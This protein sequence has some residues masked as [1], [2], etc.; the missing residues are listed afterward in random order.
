MNYCAEESL[1]IVRIEAY[2]L[3]QITIPPSYLRSRTIPVAQVKITGT[4]TIVSLRQQS[5]RPASNRAEDEAGPYF[6]NSLSWQS[7]DT[8]PETMTQ[9]ADLENNEHHFIYYL[10]GGARRL[11]YNED[12]FGQSFAQVTGGEEEGANVNISMQSRMPVLSIIEN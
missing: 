12:G 11:M 2:T 10:Y 1:E 9:I 3:D 8:S 7:D 6:T 4:P 5:A